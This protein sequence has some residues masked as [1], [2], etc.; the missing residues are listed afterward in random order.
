MAHLLIRS[1]HTVTWVLLFLMT[2][3]G[4]PTYLNFV[5]MRTVCSHS[6]E[7]VSFPALNK[8]LYI[9]LIRSKLLYC[10]QLYSPRYLREISKLE[11]IQRRATKFMLS[12]PSCSYNGSVVP[13]TPT[14]SNVPLR[15]TRHLLHSP[16]NF[17]VLHFISFCESGGT[18]ST[19][20]GHLKVNFKRTSTTRHFYFN[21]VVRLWN[22]VPPT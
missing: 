3:P 12:F 11:L 4:Q 2:S 22:S 13:T 19:S 15:L 8:S 6:L 18:R 17:D 10:C 20:Y 7:K 9:T 16:D 14:T 1:Q 5:L 21:R